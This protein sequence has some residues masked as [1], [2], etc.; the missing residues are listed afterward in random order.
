[1]SKNANSIRVG[2]IIIFE[3]RMWRV[4]KTMHTMP[5]KGGAFVQMELKDIKTGTKNN[6]RFRS[7]ESVDTAH[8]EERDF[9]FL[10][11]NGNE[12]TLMDSITFDQIEV[13]AELFGDA[14]VYLQDGM[15]VGVEIAEEQLIAA[16]VPTMVTL[17]VA[18]T[19][20]ALKGQTAAGSNKPAILENGVRVMVPTFIEVDEM[21]V[22]NTTDSTYVERAKN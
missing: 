15:K 16:N 20:G 4:L 6:Q 3:N 1:M 12:I 8:F 17:K 21:I 11:R 14:E 2:N 10:F 7:A 9:T 5:G 13:D 19:E 18:E 22:V